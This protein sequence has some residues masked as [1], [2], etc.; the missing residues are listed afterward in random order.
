MRAWQGG[1]PFGFNILGFYLMSTVIR[2]ALG[3]I[4]HR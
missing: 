2:E 4:F 1:R 3:K